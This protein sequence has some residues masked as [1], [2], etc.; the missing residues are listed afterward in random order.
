MKFLI[1]GLGSVGKRHLRNLIDLGQKDIVLYR[2]HKG[3]LPQDSDLTSF[4]AETDLHRALDHKPDAVIISNPTALHTQVAVPAAEAG[5]ALFI[6]KPL[7][8]QLDDLMEFEALLA[9]KPVKVFM[10]FQFRFNPGLRTIKQ[11]IEQD[12]IGKPLSFHC[13]WG[14]YL[15]DFHPWEDYRNNYAARKDLGG[16]VVSTL[17][18]P[19]DYLRWLFGDAMELYA[20]TGNVSDLDLD[21]EDQAEVLFK[22]NTALTGN[23]HLDFYR[24]H[25][26]HDLEICGS[27]AILFWDYDSN[28]VRLRIGN[29]SEKLINPPSG[30]QRNHM[31]LDEM[32][33]FIQIVQEGI[34]P[35]CTYEDGKRA[36]QLAW[37]I[38]Q[39]G[40]YHQRVFFD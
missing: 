33:H 25:K 11:M 31:F 36:L 10:A 39:S 19:L 6:E 38:L 7:A 2:T 14:E 9:V 37:G 17:C 15:P 34:E 16:G 12:A 30:H 24:R 32:K 27:K 29:E 1:A 21:V 4:P 3:G 40:Q 23:L 26:R 28:I 18:H 13:H 5:C 22:F 35:L 20:M 8:Y